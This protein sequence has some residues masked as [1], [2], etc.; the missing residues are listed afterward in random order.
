ML[1]K[2]YKEWPVQGLRIKVSGS[3]H[4]MV[5]RELWVRYAKDA[6]GES[7]SIADE[8]EGL[9]FEIPFDGMLE[10]LKKEAR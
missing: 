3:G 2:F 4:S 8:N 6:A 9:M 10:R 7:L 5:K 1:N